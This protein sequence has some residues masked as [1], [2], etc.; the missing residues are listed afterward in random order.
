MIKYKLL[1]DLPTIKAGKIAESFMKDDYEIISF[2]DFENYDSQTFTVK[3]CNNKPEWFEKITEEYKVGDWV[4]HRDYIYPRKILKINNNNSYLAEILNRNVLETHSDFLIDYIDRLATDNEIENFLSIMAVFK[5]FV[6]GA[7]FKTAEDKNIWTKFGKDLK[8]KYNKNNESLEWWGGTS[9]CINDGYENSDGG[10]LVIYEK[11]KWNEIVEQKKEEPIKIGP[12]YIHIPECKD[13]IEIYSIKNNDLVIIYFKSK[14][15]KLLNI[16]KY[17]YIN[18]FTVIACSGEQ[19]I[20]T[21]KIV[22][23]ICKYLE[24]SK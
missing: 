1:K 22:E 15:K 9:K 8:F 14:I 19:F 6:P 7:H 12:Y 16:M 2:S 18:T 10:F 23:T 24:E 3:F 5:G 4:K 11:G 17:F 13:W 21:K 20:V